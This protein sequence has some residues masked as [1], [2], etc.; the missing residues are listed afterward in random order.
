MLS[1]VAIAEVRLTRTEMLS[2]WKGGG[3]GMFSTTDDGVTRRM[4]V[5]VS[6]PDGE[7]DIALPAPLS[8]QAYE[9]VVFPS[10]TRLRSLGRRI[11]G[12]EAARGHSVSAVRIAVWRMAYDRETLEARPVVVRDVLVP[13]PPIDR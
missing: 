13:I 6:G 9:A 5:R 12:F 8:R 11:A 4:G 7:R 10:R 1:I 3:F 2:P